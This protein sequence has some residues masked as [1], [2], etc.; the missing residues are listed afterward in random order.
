MSRHSAD[1]NRLL[2]L[3]NMLKAYPLEC[4]SA[5]GVDRWLICGVLPELHVGIRLAVEKLHVKEREIVGQLIEC[6]PLAL[7]ERR[8]FPDE[9]ARFKVVKVS[10][11][12]AALDHATRLQKFIPLYTALDGRKCPDNRLI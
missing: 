12:I 4:K 1:A 8:K 11:G 9:S 6:V 5:P 2:D 10:R 7:A 3:R